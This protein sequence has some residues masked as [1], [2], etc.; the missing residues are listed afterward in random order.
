MLLQKAGSQTKAK[1]KK[2]RHS[3]ERNVDMYVKKKFISP[4]KVQRSGANSFVNGSSDDRGIQKSPEQKRG[5]RGTSLAQFF[6]KIAGVV[7]NIA[8]QPDDQ[9]RNQESNDLYNRLDGPVEHYA[10]SNS[11]I[12]DIKQS[13]SK[14]TMAAQLQKYKQDP[15]NHILPQGC[16]S[17]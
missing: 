9:N 16:Y 17:P 10:G 4:D 14:L 3:L 13:S 11:K 12:Q 6:D 15:Q 1:S 8:H 7:T 2:T 5:E